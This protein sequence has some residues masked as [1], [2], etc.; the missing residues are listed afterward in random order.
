MYVRRQK[1]QK[2]LIRR[3]Q[4]VSF[5]CRHFSYRATHSNSFTHY[6]LS[7][8]AYCFHY[9]LSLRRVYLKYDF[10]YITLLRYAWGFSP[11]SYFIFTRAKDDEFLPRWIF[12]CGK[13][14]VAILWR[15]YWSRHFVYRVVLSFAAWCDYY[16]T[17]TGFSRACLFLPSCYELLF[18]LY[19]TFTFFIIVL[20]LYYL[21]IRLLTYF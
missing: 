9:E 20:V 2:G 17:F 6:I 16:S 1:F 8:R 3:L 15:R 19:I 14:Q 11:P 7:P 10:R 13:P 12:D 21:L 4:K 5:R 18:G